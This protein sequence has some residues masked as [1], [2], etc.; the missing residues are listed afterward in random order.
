MLQVK[1]NG[2]GEAAIYTNSIAYQAKTHSGGMMVTFNAEYGDLPT[3]SLAKV[4]SLSGVSVAEHHVL[5]NAN[6]KKCAGHRTSSRWIIAG[7]LLRSRSTTIDRAV[8]SL[9]RSHC[10]DRSDRL[11]IFS[12]G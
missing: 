10:K 7:C 5:C 3:L 9:D 6:W 2:V 8:M 4:S 1:V 11:R 12:A